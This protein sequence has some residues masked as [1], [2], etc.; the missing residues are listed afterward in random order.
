M[1]SRDLGQLPVISGGRLEGIIS[2]G[3][4]LQYLQTRLE[5]NM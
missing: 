5:L 2:R 3:N 4:I 1:A